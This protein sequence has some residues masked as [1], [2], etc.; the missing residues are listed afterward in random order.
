MYELVKS[1]SM[2]GDGSHGIVRLDGG[3]SADVEAQRGI[4]AISS[5]QHSLG[6]LWSS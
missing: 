1:R 3:I 4:L 2:A 6:N 5:E